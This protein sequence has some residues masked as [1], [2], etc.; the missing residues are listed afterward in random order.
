MTEISKLSLQI[1]TNSPAAVKTGGESG[2]KPLELV[3][4]MD[5]WPWCQGHSEGD[6]QTSNSL[7]LN[8]E[9]NFHHAWVRAQ[10]QQTAG[11]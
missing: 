1:L 4:A 11:G 2:L 7:G 3:S 5:K 10:P 8:S 6:P 9:A